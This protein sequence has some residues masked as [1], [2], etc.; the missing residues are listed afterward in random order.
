MSSKKVPD[1]RSKK[2]SKKNSDNPKKAGIQASVPKEQPSQF[3]LMSSDELFAEVLHDTKS[4]SL[5]K[6]YGITT[7]ITPRVEI[8][9]KESFPSKAHKISLP[10][11]SLPKISLPKISLPKIS[12]P[13]ISLPKIS[14]PK[15]SLPKISLPKIS[16]PK[17][18]EETNYFDESPRKE[19]I[20]VPAFLLILA[21]AIV[22]AG[23]WGPQLLRGTGILTDPKPFTAIYFQDP[24]I[25]QHGIAS[26]DL[27]IVGIHN[28]SNHPRT[29]TWHADSGAMRIAQGNIDLLANSDS[30]FPIMSRGAIAGQKFDIYVEGT[31]APISIDVIG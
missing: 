18:S 29:I 3:R 6:Q 31:Q 20:R 21:V 1:R 30:L 7:A 13:K 11:I 28:G 23:F 2:V 24:T 9:G 16:L 10:K 26:G 17:I 4:K 25:V 5:F 15:I 22:I 12:L 27:V 14:L 8:D 19:K